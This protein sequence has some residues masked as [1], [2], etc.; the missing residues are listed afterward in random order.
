MPTRRQSLLTLPSPSEKRE[1]Y[2]AFCK[3]TTH[4]PWWQKPFV[5]NHPE[6]ITHAYAFTQVGPCVLFV[7]PHRDRID[8]TMKYPENDHTHLSA[9]RLAI[10]L[11]EAYHT[12]IRHEF[13]PDLQD[14][15]SWLNFIPTCVSVVK[16]SS[17]YPSLAVTPYGLLKCLMKRGA[18][19]I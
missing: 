1:W 12:V 3:N 16:V 13:V 18:E 17:G 2:F 8:F 5:R 9:H 19:P 14:K 11:G 6:N 4:I 15:R 7:E 10:E